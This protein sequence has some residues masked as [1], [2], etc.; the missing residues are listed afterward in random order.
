MMDR[1]VLEA[2]DFRKPY[3]GQELHIEDFFDG[4]LEFDEA[5]HLATM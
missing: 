2:N 4:G 1:F 3:V 5:D